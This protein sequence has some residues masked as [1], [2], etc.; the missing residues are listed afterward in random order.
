MSKKT[1]YILLILTLVVVGYYA[2]FRE[3]TD[4]SSKE[5]ERTLINTSRSN[6]KN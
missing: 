4:E 3:K 5:G 1:L 2:F 6:V